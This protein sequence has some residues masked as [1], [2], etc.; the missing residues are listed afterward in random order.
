MIGR[1]RDKLHA[2][3]TGDYQTGLCGSE[4]NNTTN[5]SLLF[6][7]RHGRRSCKKCKA[8]IRSRP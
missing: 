6:S 4:R 8:A 5:W 3:R 2:S 1:K 7:Y